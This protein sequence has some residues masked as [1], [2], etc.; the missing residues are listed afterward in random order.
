M[1]NLAMLIY[2]MRNRRPYQLFQQYEA[3]QWQPVETV[4]ERQFAAVR[5]LVRLAY[6]KT[7]YYRTLLDSIGMKP[8]DLRSAADFQAIPILTKD[9][10]RD[11]L[12]QMITQGHPYS[13]LKKNTSG[14]STGTPLTFYQ[15]KELYLKMEANGLLGLSM[16]GWTGSGKIFYFWGNPREFNG[17]KKLLTRLKERISNRVLFNSYSY[18]EEKIAGWVQEIRRAGDCYLYGY[19]SVLADVARFV[20]DQGIAVTSVRGILSTAE[21]LYPWQREL[22]ESSFGARVFDQYG[23]REVPGMACECGHGTMHLLPHS[24]Y[25]EFLEDPAQAS[26]SKKIITTCLTNF[27]MPF[28]RYDIGDYARPKEGACPCGRGFPSLEMDIGRSTDRFLTPEGNLVY[29]TFFVR[30]MYGSDKVQN[31][32]FHQISPELVRLYV[33]RCAGFDGSDALRLERV[34]ENIREQVSPAMGLD[35]Q[36]VESIPRTMG[37]KHRFVISDVVR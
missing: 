36:Y 32:Q 23:S 35:I 37:G 19:T 16:A 26:G 34:G 18:N 24:A 27:A 25:L 12:E 5:E 6:E 30:Q 21:K 4:R 28:I 13:D 17:G 20:R 29:G 2:R 10:I 15:E 11:N 31:F 8:G 22:L 3:Y 7:G 14:G 33:V 9:I 1:D